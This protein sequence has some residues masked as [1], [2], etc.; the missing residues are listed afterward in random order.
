[1]KRT[2]TQAVALLATLAV[3]ACD[4][5]SAPDD[6]DVLNADL[7]VVAAD[8]TLDGLS[9][10]QDP[11]MGIHRADRTRTITFFDGSG[12][13][14]DRYDALTTASIRFTFDAAGTAARGPWSATIERHREL[15]VSGLAG[16]ETTRTWNGSGSETITRSRT[17]DE[18][19]TRT[20]D[21]A[22]EFTIANV[23]VPVPG[24]DAPWPLSGT[25]TRHYLV[26]LTTPDG[27]VTRERTVVITFNGTQTAT[28][29]VNGETFEIDLATRRG[30]LPIP[31]L[32]H[33]GRGRR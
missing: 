30:I 31:R 12:A 6:A 21:L 23:V 13:E 27:T 5:V 18:R 22:G 32:R 24:S 25:I 15:T 33:D 26:T 28:A 14:Q 8:A 29:V 11:G 10:M 17:S 4:D 7:A 19:G 9:V 16:E 2:V 1:M 3:S 20:Y